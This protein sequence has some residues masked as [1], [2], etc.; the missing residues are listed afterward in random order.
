MEPATI[1][2]IVDGMPQGDVAM[3]FAESGYNSGL[4]Q[5]YRDR[6]G[7]KCV[8]LNVGL[9]YDAKAGKDMPTFEKM[10]FNEARSRGYDAPTLYLT[11][12]TILRKDEW[13]MFD[14]VVVESA[15]PRLRV[16]SDLAAANTYSL[17]GMA[18][19][20]LEHET[21]NDPGEA[22]V[23]MTGLADGR[24]DTILYQLEGMPLPITYQNFWFGERD[25]ATSRKSG[26]PLSTMMARIAGRRV[27]ETI[28][29][30]TLGTTTGLT[31]GTAANYGRTPT[32]YGYTNH[33]ARNLSASLTTPTGSNSS[34][35]VSQ[36]LA[37]R[38][39]LYADGF[40]GP[41]VIYNGTDWDQYLDDDH[42]K[43]VTSGGAAPTG[44]L[45][46]R[47]VQIDDVASVRRADYLTPANTGGTFDLIMVALG[48]PEVARAVIG[49]PIRILQWPSRGGMQMNFKVMAIMAPQVRADYAGN[50]GINHGSVS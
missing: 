20:M 29:K 25:L 21:I 37:M 11:N 48:N 44:T 7:N 12:A 4:Y 17:D 43:Y 34:T 41:F 28:E 22:I 32:V 18:N 35:T 40:F 49:M 33:P 2:N 6:N 23:D 38:S 36:V 26:A 9:K 14:R 42:F 45:R 46:Q 50:S 24:S 3:E 19:K 16:W 15:R 47:L 31:Y 10:T 13:I 8:T 39:A 27:A 30:T 1:E 5:P